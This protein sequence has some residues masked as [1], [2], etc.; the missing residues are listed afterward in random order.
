MSV[1]GLLLQTLG[2]LQ[3]SKIPGGCESCN[4]YQTVEPTMA[5]A[6]HIRVHHDDDC[7]WLAARK[8]QAA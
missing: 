5:G 6:W 3:G 8:G 2:P 4:A 7:K 1:A